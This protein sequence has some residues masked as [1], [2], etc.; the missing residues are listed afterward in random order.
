MHLTEGI[1]Y[2]A[3]VV[4]II[5][6]GI[7]VELTDHRTELIHISNIS[8]KYIKDISEIVS[9]GDVYSAKGIVGKRRP[10]ELSLKHLNLRP[11]MQVAK[12]SETATTKDSKPQQSID[13]MIA[14]CNRQYQDKFAAKFSQDKAHNTALFNKRRHR[15]RQ[16]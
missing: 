4:R 5:P 8:D 14:E 7:I 2:L 13:D 3:K 6:T 9:V 10:V 1:T 16:S 12:I 11:P 15:R